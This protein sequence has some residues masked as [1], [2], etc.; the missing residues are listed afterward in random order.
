MRN[1]EYLTAGLCFI[2]GHNIRGATEAYR[3]ESKT[4]RVIRHHPKA[5]RTAPLYWLITGGR[6]FITARKPETDP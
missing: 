4:V 6:N 1:H 2:V 5:R 3:E